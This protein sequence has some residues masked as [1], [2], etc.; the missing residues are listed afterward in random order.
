MFI[1]ISRITVIYSTNCPRWEL[2][3]QEQS[4]YASTICNIGIIRISYAMEDVKL[5][6]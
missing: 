4:W 2:C 5:K 1:Y 6:T 3:R